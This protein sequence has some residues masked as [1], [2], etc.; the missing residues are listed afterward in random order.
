MK[1]DKN[2]FAAVRA[3]PH[4]AITKPEGEYRVAYRLAS[5]AL[6]DQG[7]KGIAW[8][9]QQAENTSYYTDC[10][11]DAHATAKLLSDHMVKA[12]AQKEEGQ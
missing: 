3:M 8:Q 7:H 11:L 9:R 4:M 1:T 5:I 10:R 2:L 12:L 6:I